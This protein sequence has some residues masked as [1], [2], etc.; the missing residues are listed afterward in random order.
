MFFVKVYT[1][2]YPM[3]FNMDLVDTLHVVRYWSEVLCFT[4]ITCLCNIQVIAMVFGIELLSSILNVLVKI[5]GS[6]YLLNIFIHLGPTLLLLDIVK[7]NSIYPKRYILSFR[8]FVCSCVL[9]SVLWNLCHSFVLK[10]LKWCISQQLF[11]TKHSY[12]DDSYPTG[13]AFTS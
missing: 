11:I 13:L 9:P 3:N 7:K 2:L 8:S 6:V 1:S 5:F 4:I 12:L 10:F